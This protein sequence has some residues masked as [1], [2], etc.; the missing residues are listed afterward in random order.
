MNAS[1]ESQDLASGEIFGLKTFEGGSAKIQRLP[2]IPEI[3]NARNMSDLLEALTSET[4]Q[5]ILSDFAT[6]IG[7]QGYDSSS[8]T[9]LLEK[10]KTLLEKQKNGGLNKDDRGSI[11]FG[12]RYIFSAMFKTAGNLTMFWGGWTTDPNTESIKVFRGTDIGLANLD[13][14]V[15][16]PTR[17]FEV[18]SQT[19]RIIYNILVSLFNQASNDVNNL[20]DVGAIK[21]RAVEIASQG[22]N[23]VEIGFGQGK[24]SIK[25]DYKLDK[26]GK[27]AVVDVNAGVMGIPD[28]TDLL[29]NRLRTSLGLERIEATNA[30]IE[31][32]M[33]TYNSKELKFPQN[34]SV[35]VLDQAMY[36]SNSEDVDL[37][38]KAINEFAAKRG[39]FMNVNVIFTDGESLIPI[40]G[41]RS[42][43][44]T[45]LIFRYTNRT[46]L[47]SDVR[48]SIKGTQV[49]P[50]PF[51]NLIA[52]K[53]S[54]E[55]VQNLGGGSF[56]P[57]I[58]VPEEVQ[59]KFETGMYQA[60]AMIDEAFALGIEKGWSGIVIKTA[61]KFRKQNSEG[62]D[63]PTAFIYPLTE[64]GREVAIDE[65]K[66]I[67]KGLAK[68]PKAASLKLS[69]NQLF[70]GSVESDDSERQVEIRLIT[71]LEQ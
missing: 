19:N 53:A 21:E 51:T 16:V 68:D 62:K 18:L 59:S 54:M 25:I 31:A 40:E 44:S 10:S 48:E 32:V 1:I 37:Y 61:T 5:K 69:F 12:L 33:A 60:A 42:L 2:V 55:M 14:G 58:V 70:T 52:D 8:I 46:T 29:G 66:S 47:S 64:I 6:Q 45:D 36:N 34:V 67:L 50:E 26:A 3:F 4:N 49:I 13:Y 24:E 30:V 9:R 23:G 35:L 7:L 57:E 56:S 71:V 11:F 17:T 63:F 28:G 22:L 38:V 65:M 15:Q 20:S 43:S 39:M 27:A 41:N